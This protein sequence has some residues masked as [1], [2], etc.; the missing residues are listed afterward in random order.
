MHGVWRLGVKYLQKF[1]FVNTFVYICGWCNITIYGIEE[2]YDKFPRWIGAGG[3]R[4]AWSIHM[5]SAG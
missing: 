3:W 5:W 1:Y 4:Y 2:C